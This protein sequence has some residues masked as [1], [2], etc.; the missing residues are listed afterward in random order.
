MNKIIIKKHRNRNDYILTNQGLWVRNFTK[1]A[2]PVDINSL[3]PKNDYELLIS[4]QMQNSTIN[5]ANIDAEHIIAKNVIIVSDGYKFK[6]K[7]SLLSKL[8]LDN[9]VIIGT[10]RSLAKWSDIRMDYYVVNN[11][12]KECMSYLPDNYFPRCIC[13]VRTYPQFIKKYLAKGNVYK[14]VPVGDDKFSGI[15]EPPRYYIDDYRNPICAALGLA[16]RWEVQRLLLFCCDDVFDGERPGAEK[17]SNGLWMY[18]QHYTS[19]ELILGNLFWLAKNNVVLGNYSS[20]PDYEH[21]PYI[22]DDEL[23]RFF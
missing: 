17:L 2:R 8:P 12:Y 19:H 13:S 14:Y 3:T 10:N 4:N 1:A 9:V 23:L 11:P 20:S 5:L 16:Y 18:P 21:V 15:I 7:L 6:E 22:T